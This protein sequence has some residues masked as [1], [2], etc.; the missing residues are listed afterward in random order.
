[1]GQ[2]LNPL[3]TATRAGSLGGDPEMGM[4]LMAVPLLRA[5]RSPPL[6]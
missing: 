6:G 5:H 4:A 2:A 3:P 1:M